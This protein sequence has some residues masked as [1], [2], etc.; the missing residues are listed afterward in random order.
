MSLNHCI[1]HKIERA[2]PAAPVVTSLA[3]SELDIQGSIIS[4]FEQ[5]KL[6]YHRSAQKR[7]GHFDYEQSANPLPGLLKDYLEDKSS[8]TSFCKNT[9]AHLKS[10]YEAIDEPFSAHVLFAIAGSDLQKH[11]FV[12]WITHEDVL[13]ISE[14]LRVVHSQYINTS[15]LQFAIKLNLEE[16]LEGDS[17]RYMS[18]YANRGNKD[19]TQAFMQFSAFEMGVDLAKETNEF[20]GIVDQFTEELPP[21]EIIAYKDKLLDY[22]VEQDKFGNPVVMTELS[23]F[24]NE[25]QPEQFANYVAEQQADPK[26][27]IRTDRASLKRYVRYY[28][29][30]KN[31]SISFSAN[32]YGHGVHYNID[33]DTLTI[34][35]IPKSLK[36]QLTKNK[37]VE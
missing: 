19:L 35:Q 16:W 20:L 2:L 14:D 32:M 1:I 6:R 15:R 3:E 34:N 18:L 37:P 22:C 24:V 27:E 11:L 12:F 17:N 13:Q 33:A 8:F 30:D 9:M 26:P 36:S 28:G 5:L 29:R 10:Q 21:E 4:L 25:Q 23:S 31:L 7:Y